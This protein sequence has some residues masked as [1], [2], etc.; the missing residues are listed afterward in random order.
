METFNKGKLSRSLFLPISFAVGVLGFGSP[1]YFS[2]VSEISLSDI[3]K[4]TKSLDQEVVR[5]LRQNNL[6]PAEM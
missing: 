2:T 4:G 1:V 6:G 5:Q 3:G